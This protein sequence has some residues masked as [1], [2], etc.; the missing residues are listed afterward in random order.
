[1]TD[2]ERMELS[3]ARA[4]KDAAHRVYKKQQEKFNAVRLRL[5]NRCEQRLAR[6]R[7]RAPEGVSNVC[8]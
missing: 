7:A 2:A 1:M 6:A 8:D 3:E 4:P 5:K